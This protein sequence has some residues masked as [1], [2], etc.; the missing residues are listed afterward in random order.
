MIWIALMMFLH[1][2]FLYWRPPEVNVNV[3]HSSRT[4][5]LVL[6]AVSAC[7]CL[8]DEDEEEKQEEPKKETT[9]EESKGSACQLPLIAQLI[10]CCVIVC[11]LFTSIKDWFWELPRWRK[12]DVLAAFVSGC[13]NRNRSVL[14]RSRSM[15]ARVVQFLAIGY[16][17]GTGVLMKDPRP[18]M[19]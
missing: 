15:V 14:V 16:A 4:R 18:Q 3:T 19:H 8:Q 2:S 10:V 13:F 12:H 6:I 1:A 17:I 9:T 7:E 5:T 11:S